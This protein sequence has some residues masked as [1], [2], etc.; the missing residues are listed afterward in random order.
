MTEAEPVDYLGTAP[1]DSERLLGAFPNPDVDLSPVVPLGFDGRQVI[2]AM[3]EGEIRKEPAAKI[4]QMLRTDIYACQ[5]G[6]SFLSYWRDK[7]DKFQRELA[8][9]WFN[10]ACRDAGKWDPNRP[11]RS[12]GVWPG[13]DGGVVLH[14]GE[15]IL[16]YRFD[17]TTVR[18]TIA[19][20]LKVKRGPLYQLRPPAPEAGA[21]MSKRHGRWIRKQLDW[22]RFEDIGADGLSGADIVAGW[23]TAGLL[24]AAAPFRGHVLMHA[25]QGSGKSSLLVFINALQSALAGEI[26]TSFSEAGFRAD[27]SGMA[28]PQLVDE[29]EAGDGTNGPGAVEQVLT[30][31]R[32]MST[33][34]GARRVQSDN[35]GGTTTQTA[36]GSVMMAA[37]TP[38]KMDAALA[39][40]VAEIRLM[41][42]TGT[43]LD[44]N[45]E[46]PRIATRRTL[47]RINAQAQRIAPHLLGRVLANAGRY[48]EDV[49][50]IVTALVASGEEPRNADLIAMLAAGRRLLLEDDPLTAQTAEEEA[51]RWRPMLAERL[52]REM[53]SNV[54]ADAL[55]HLMGWNSGQHRGDRNQ[56]L[57]EVIHTHLF[58]KVWQTDVLKAHGL[59]LHEDPGKDG[60]PGPWLLVCNNHPVLDRIF[61]KT[62]WKDYRTA[63]E[64]LDAL[65]PEYRTVP[66]KPLRFGV[67]I[68]QRALAIPLA[69]WLEKPFKRST[70]VPGSVPGQAYE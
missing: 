1:D 53:V 66:A 41:P 7:D 52:H 10:R 29:A 61:G 3:P 18:R 58:E 70:S 42:L 25:L 27:I 31:L 14:R 55:A 11:V 35:A 19:E 67:G 43:D 40:R 34:T 16:L 9:V 33:G 12:L 39:S 59:I 32:L 37:I 30:L 64:F 69:P 44:P 63:L 50:S 21:P 68:K 56:T 45:A 47:A 5:A 8:T 17:G 24:G 48:R 26:V 49:S 54:G 13:G 57:G 15:E 20:A 36:V 62:R 23:L 2:F 28:R 46:R 6:Q 51:S 4:G 38:P 65:G 60:R 22:W